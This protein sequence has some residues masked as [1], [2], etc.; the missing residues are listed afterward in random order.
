[1]YVCMHGLSA[2]SLPPR[3]PRTHAPHTP[4]SRLVMYRAGRGRQLIR[5]YDTRA[6]DIH[7]VISNRAQPLVN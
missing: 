2:S 3:V 7:R 4:Q 1:M 6:M 5:M